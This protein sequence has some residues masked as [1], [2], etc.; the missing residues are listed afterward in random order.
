MREAYLKPG[1]YT[2]EELEEM[3]LCVSSAMPSMGA[4][5][6]PG[7]LWEL[8]LSNACEYFFNDVHFGD[9]L[10]P[11]I[12]LAILQ[13]DGCRLV[14]RRWVDNHYAQILWKLAGL[15]RA[16]PSF[17]SSRWNWSEVIDQLKYRYERETGRAERPI[18]RRIQEHDS[19]GAVPMVL[20]VSA[21]RWVATDAALGTAG[22]AGQGG[23]AGNGLQHGLVG[24][25]GS[26]DTRQAGGMKPF[27]ELTDGWYRIHAEIDGC[28]TKAVD[29]GRI[30]PGQKLAICG[31]K[32]RPAVHTVFG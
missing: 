3:G 7:D 24:N 13:A 6:R 1:Y 14:T 28:L 23:Q 16:Q 32:V 2:R 18:V 17:F 10:G 29:K 25:K 30:T 31:A 8:D 22:T 9:G 20:V 11:A 12:A 21:V 27:L 4:D 26:Q 5:C 15:C 19:S